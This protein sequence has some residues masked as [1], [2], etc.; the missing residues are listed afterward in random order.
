M[1][2]T[3]VKLNKINGTRKTLTRVIYLLTVIFMVSFFIKS[4]QQAD[5]VL[6]RSV[7]GI[8]CT[9]AS[10]NLALKHYHPVTDRPRHR[11]IRYACAVYILISRKRISMSECF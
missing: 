6:Y 5:S 2:L 11:S 9:A 1:K 8:I 3:S 4:E 7:N 10:T